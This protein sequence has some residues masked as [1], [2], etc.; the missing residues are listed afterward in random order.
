MTDSGGRRAALAKARQ[1]RRPSRLGTVAG[2]APTPDQV[3]PDDAG[4][5]DLLRTAW[6]QAVA[7]P[8]LRSAVTT[9]AT[10]GGHVPAEVQLRALATSDECALA[11][12]YGVSWRDDGPRTPNGQ[13]DPPATGNGHKPA[14]LGELGLTTSGRIV[15]RVPSQGPLDSE[16]DLVDGV[17]WVPWPADALVRYQEALGHALARRALA[18]DDCRQWLADAGPAGQDELLELLMEAAIR[19]APFILYQEDKRYTNFRDRN[20]ITG[21]TL[22]PGHPDCALNSL[23]GVPL[24]LWS[25]S[26]VLLVVCL[27]L[28]VRSA[29]FGRIEE[30][31]CTQL[32]IDHVAYL[33]E[34]TRRGY[35]TV[36]GQQPVP[37]AVSTRVAHLHDLAVALRERRQRFGSGVQLYRE[38][39]GALMHKVERVADAGRAGRQQ[40]RTLC[41]RLCDTLPVRGDTLA[42]LGESLTAAPHWLAEPHGGFGTGLES[43]VYQTVVGARDAFGADFAMSRGAR[44][45]PKL[46]R[47]LRAADWPEITGWDITEYF[48]CVVPSP[49][50]SRYFTDS[51]ARLADIS[52]SISSRMQYNSWHFIAGNLPRVPEVIKRDYFVPPTIPDIAFYSDQHHHGHVAARVRFSIRS[53][54]PVQVL[55]RTFTGFVDLRLLR[56]DGQPFEERDLLAAHRGSAFLARATTLAADLVAAGADIEIASFDPAWHLAVIADLPDHDPAP[57]S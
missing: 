4:F 5:P 49:G 1:S 46:V 35:N 47:A 56:C 42:E 37:P 34:R 12:L 54:Q 38:I 50:A 40:E 25:D 14:F 41:E 16:V 28:L 7:A 57:V 51:A 19:T 9:L 36:P 30:A 26:D 10:L 32:S 29:G 2:A 53:P 3:L 43:L 17:L 21:K 27:T 20:T 48:C 31:N 55:D 15:V 6:Q 44:S 13:P 22:W 11:A 39:H 45:L 52:W 33:L 18:T 24:D 8:D 23:K